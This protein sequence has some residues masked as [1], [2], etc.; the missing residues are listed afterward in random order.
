MTTPLRIARATRGLSQPA[1][2]R[3][4]GINVCTVSSIENQK[5]KPTRRTRQRIAEAL[6]APEHLIFPAGEKP[7][8]RLDPSDSAGVTPA[9]ETAEA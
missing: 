2:A 3:M 1:L 4:A 7:A 6:G 9:S 8:A 5:H